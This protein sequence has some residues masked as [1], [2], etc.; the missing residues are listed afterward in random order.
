MALARR[1]LRRDPPMASYFDDLK[2][3]PITTASL[4]SGARDMSAAGAAPMMQ[5]PQE[6][7]WVKKQ[8][9]SYKLAEQ[10]NQPAPQQAGNWP[11]WLSPAPA[12]PAPEPQAAGP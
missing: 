1:T 4:T 9:P 5:P 6:S 3:P 7:P 12:A 10:A 2:A 8:V 11:S